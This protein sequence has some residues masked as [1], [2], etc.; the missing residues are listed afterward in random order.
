MKV[1]AYTQQSEAEKFIDK[2]NKAAGFEGITS[3]GAPTKKDG[4]FYV[5]WEQC[6]PHLGKGKDEF[7]DVKTTEVADDYFDPPEEEYSTTEL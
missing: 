3:F 2:M 5:L 7:N 4:I 1:L 6:C